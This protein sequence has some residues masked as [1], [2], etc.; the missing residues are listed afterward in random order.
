MNIAFNRLVE[1]SMKS[2][3]Y[4]SFFIIM[5]FLLGC[6]KE[7]DRNSLEAQLEFIQTY[8]VIGDPVDFDVSDE[9]IFVAEDE[10]GFSIFNRQSSELHLRA[11]E[12]NMLQIRNVPL[13]RYNN[14]FKML[15]VVD[16]TNGHVLYAINVDT[17]HSS[18]NDY[19]VK[20]IIGSAYNVRDIIFETIP[21][22]DTKFKMY[23]T[24]FKF[25]ENKNQLMEGIYTYNSTLS[26]PLNM[27]PYS[28][29]NSI[30]KIK[31]T[32]NHIFTAM[33]QRGIVIYDKTNL[34]EIHQINTPGEARDM[35]INNNNIYVADRQQGLQIIDITDISN[36]ILLE[37]SA[38]L[39]NGFA[40]SIDISGRFLALGSGSGGVYLYD[41]SNPTT[42]ILIDHLDE[43]EIGY[44]HKILFFSNDLYISSKSHGIVRYQVQ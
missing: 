32:N 7:A 37:A 29:P 34:T 31:S 42:P 5:S 18:I 33:G 24:N 38:R 22:E 30:F 40:S 12:H 43:D 17:L 8:P 23:L 26:N 2:Y 3:I 39:T 21:D 14:D 36:P 16:R 1:E 19:P 25:D 35:I 6:A 9:C 15:F 11:N 10:I 13:V 27:T 28:V 41:I 4:L 20:R 44:V